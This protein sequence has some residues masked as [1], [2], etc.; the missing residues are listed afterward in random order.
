MERSLSLGKTLVVFLPPP[1]TWVVDTGQRSHSGTGRNRQTTRIVTEM[2]IHT[3]F[4]FVVS[5]TSARGQRMRIVAGDPFATFWR[6]QK[7][8]L[9]YEAYM[10][11]PVGTLAAVIEGTEFAIAS[12]AT[13]DKGTVLILPQPAFSRQVRT[14]K[15]Q[16]TAFL[17]ALIELV[18]SVRSQTGDF[19]L[20]AWTENV[21]LPGEEEATEKLNRERAR[22]AKLLAAVDKRKQAIGLLRERKLLFTGS[23]PALER[24]AEQAF[25]ALGFAVEQGRP[26]RTDRLL[27]RDGRVAV[28][29]LKGKG[30]SA[31]EADAAQ[32]EKWVSEYQLEHSEQPKAILVVNA[33][34]NKVLSERTENAFPDQMLPYCEGRGH[35]LLTG[36]QLLGAWIEVQRKPEKAEEIALSMLECV[37]RYPDYVDWRDYLDEASDAVESGEPE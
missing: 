35:C 15:Q 31:A 33:W 21:R 22:L 9:F 18:E 2:E 3:A 6:S 1:I 19:A 4:P 5:T 16:D 29:E 14:G 10:N 32:L 36:L 28:A 26:G 30:K 24:L 27:R 37:G 7:D 11:D 8:R 12:I 13:V 23:G 34:K 17:S 20:P 25:K